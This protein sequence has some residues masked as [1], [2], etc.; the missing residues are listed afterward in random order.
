MADLDATNG[1]PLVLR[2]STGTERIMQEIAPI[3]KKPQVRSLVEAVYEGVRQE[4]DRKLRVFSSS[5]LRKFSSPCSLMEH[6]DSH[7]I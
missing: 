6:L 4:K 3:I 1:A 7:R 2:R 5:F